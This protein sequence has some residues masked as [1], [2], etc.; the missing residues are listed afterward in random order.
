MQFLFLTIL[1]PL[2]RFGLNFICTILHIVSFLFAEGGLM[3]GV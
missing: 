1:K 2:V 3:A